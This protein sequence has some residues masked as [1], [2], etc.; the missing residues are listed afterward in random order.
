MDQSIPQ[1]RLAVSKRGSLSSLTDLVFGLQ[2][3][4]A[5]PTI[6][7][8]IGDLPACRRYCQPRNATGI[9]AFTERQFEGDPNVRLAVEPVTGLR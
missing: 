7:S 9:F 3:R 6:S 2:S 5:S 4:N 1:S 8:S